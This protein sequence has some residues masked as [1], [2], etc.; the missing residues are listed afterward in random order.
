MFLIGM[1]MARRRR[2]EQRSASCV[3]PAMSPAQAERKLSPE[4][5]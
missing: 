2:A 3:A 5:A 1:A 4:N